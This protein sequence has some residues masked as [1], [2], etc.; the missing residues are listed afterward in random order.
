MSSP[1]H[2]ATPPKRAQPQTATSPNN[3]H[4]RAIEP[5]YAAALSKAF[6]RL[7]SDIFI[8][9]LAYMI[10]VLAV[11]ILAPRVSET[12]RALLYVVPIL[13]IV[14][15]TWGQ[16]RKIS[17]RSASGLEARVGYVDGRAEVTGTR[18]RGEVSKMPDTSARVV[19]GVARGDATVRGVDVVTG[20]EASDL[21]SDAH[22]LLDTFKALD[23]ENRKAVVLYAMQRQNK[24]T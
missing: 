23:S 20:D 10:L 24:S 8:F 1:L 11:G 16:R 3:S 19:V 4:P 9:L 12:L 21:D 13:G 18:I 6:E 5:P 17:R 7:N 2:P 15:Y 14:G 22:F